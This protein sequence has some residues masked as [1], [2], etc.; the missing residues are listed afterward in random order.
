MKIG[1]EHFLRCLE[2]V[3]PGLAT[4][5][6]IEQSQCFIFVKGQVCAFND[7]IACRGPSGLEKAFTGAVQSKSLLDILKLLPDDDI[8]VSAGD[9][10][11][12]VAGKRRRSGI[13]MEK[14]I[15]LPID[16]IETPTEWHKLHKDFCEAV[17]I[18]H[19]C[20]DEKDPKAAANVVHVH[21]KWI[22]AGTDFQACR[23]R[24]KTGFAEPAMFKPSSLKNV[25]SLGMVEFGETAGWVHFRNPNGLVL[26][27]RRYL[28]DYPSLTEFLAEGGEPAA[29]PKGLAE[30]AARA[31]VFS[32]ENTDN[33]MLEVSLRPGRLVL[34]GTGVSGWFEETPK[35][36]YNG[37]KLTFLISPKI[38]S[39]IVTKHREMTL[40]TDRLRVDAG[41]YIYTAWLFRPNVSPI[42]NGDGTHEEA[43]EVVEQES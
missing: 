9:G 4:R 15:L 16:S 43:T 33:N 18:V 23:W 22:E 2:G 29:L 41:G 31:E 17:N 11:L 26:S 28:E 24:L 13:R 40:T 12:L 35:V 21:P 8:D 5:E 38:L 6:V 25:V 34:R 10:E 36:T 3:A 42:S 14:E 7:E 30:A 39:D 19:N 20:A 32:Q 27:C 1:R 37:P